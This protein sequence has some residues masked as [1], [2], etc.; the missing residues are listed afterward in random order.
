MPLPGTATTA[1]PA[2]SSSAEGA[3][4]CLLAAA[5]G[6]ALVMTGKR[7]HGQNRTVTPY[8][9]EHRA[10]VYTARARK[11]ADRR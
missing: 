8:P 3:I 5:D 9:R 4:H 6:D 2:P 11:L 10:D 1:R 7:S